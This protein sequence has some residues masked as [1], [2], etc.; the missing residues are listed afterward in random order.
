MPKTTDSGHHPGLF[1]PLQ[2]LRHYFLQSTEHIFQNLLIL[3]HFNNI[4]IVLIWYISKFS[5]GGEI[6]DKIRIWKINF[7]NFFLIQYILHSMEKKSTKSLS[8]LLSSKKHHSTLEMDTFKVMY[9]C[10]FFLITLH[11]II[12]TSHMTLK[13]HFSI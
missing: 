8:R 1:L 5:L 3:N 4:Q 11:S 2:C 13:V 12:K 7:D 10:C 9:S 6:L